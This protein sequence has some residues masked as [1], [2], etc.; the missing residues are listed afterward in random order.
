MVD[1]HSHLISESISVIKSKT[2][3]DLNAPHDAGSIV[4]H[5][6]LALYY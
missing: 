1:Q 4:I 2:G 3:V 6:H 5:S